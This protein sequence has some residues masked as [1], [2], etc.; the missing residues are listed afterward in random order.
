MIRFWE[1]KNHD[2]DENNRRG[3]LKSAIDRIQKAEGT[4]ITIGSKEPAEE[5]EE[6]KKRKKSRNRQDQEIDSP[7]SLVNHIIL[8]ESS[9]TKWI[10]NHSFKRY[11]VSQH[12]R[13]SRLSAHD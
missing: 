4:A 9:W 11:P 3:I 2:K 6:P 12:P 1:R 8:I 5:K 10:M 13:K 7:V